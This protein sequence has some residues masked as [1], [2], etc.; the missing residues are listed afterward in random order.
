[1]RTIITMLF[2]LVIIFYAGTDLSYA[3][4][5]MKAKRFENVEW[6]TVV[7][8][9]YFTGKRGRALE[10]IDNHFKK[11]GETAGTLKPVRYEL[12]TGEWDLLL[13]WD[14]KG[15]I[16]DMTWESSPNGIAWR[17]AF[18][19]QEGGADKA[20]ALIDEYRGLIS[21]SYADIAMVK[22]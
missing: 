14:M 6:K 20:K 3:Q 2:L 7:H 15:G 11:A 4:E 19:K 8:V 1:M 13:I 5:E 21:E 9:K 22:K 16:E 18:N 12:S 17:K 10:I